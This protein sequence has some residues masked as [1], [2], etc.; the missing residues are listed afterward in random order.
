MMEP[1]L[2]TFPAVGSVR[3]TLPAFSWLVET[4]IG[5]HDEVE[6]LELRGRLLDEVRRDVGHDVGLLAG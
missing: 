3:M 5:S 2:A 6:G 4:L 1:T